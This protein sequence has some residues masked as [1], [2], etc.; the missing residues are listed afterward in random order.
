MSKCQPL[1]SLDDYLIL[2]KKKSN[3]ETN[4]FSKVYHI[5]IHFFLFQPLRN[6][7]ELD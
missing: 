2:E 7:D 1:L 6:F 3:K 4:L 5:Y